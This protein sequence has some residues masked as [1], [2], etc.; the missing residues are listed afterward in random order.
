MGIDDVVWHVNFPPASMTLVDNQQRGISV[1][2]FLGISKVVGMKKLAPGR[3]VIRLRQSLMAGL[4]IAMTMSETGAKAPNSADY[5]QGRSLLKE[6]NWSKAIIYFDKCLQRSESAEVYWRR[7]LCYLCLDDYRRAAADSSAAIKL[8]PNFSQA[9]KTRAES[10]RNLGKMEPAEADLKEC[11]KISPR[12]ID[13]YF[14]LAE[15]LQLQ[16]RDTESL[17]VL[18]SALGLGQASKVNKEMGKVYQRCRRENEAV[19]AFSRALKLEP[20]DGNCLVRRGQSYLALGRYKEAISDA[21][22]AMPRMGDKRGAALKL[23]AQAYEKLG[24]RALASKDLAQLKRIDD[25]D[26]P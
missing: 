19:A 11:I 22:E 9:Y 13:A 25:F 26:V 20:D 4:L 7:S 8:D 18:S 24:D 23:R 6:H 14:N 3:Q 21:T 2:K 5:D 1:R 12:K 17:K 16:K 10:F 15:L